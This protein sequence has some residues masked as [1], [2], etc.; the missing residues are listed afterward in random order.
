MS[1]W[2]EVYRSNVAALTAL[3]EGL[4]VE[5]LSLRVPAT[6]DW[7]VHDVLAHLAGSPADVLSGRMDGAP[8]AEWT[9]R[10]VAE[11]SARTPE[12]LVTELRGSVDGV[13]AS[14]DGSDSPA[15]VWNAAVHHADLH[16]ALGKGAP[17]EVHWR[18]VLEALAP[19]ALG[20]HADA[21]AGVPDYELFRALFSRRSRA[22]MAAWGTPLDQE[23]LDAMCLFGPRD[24]DQ[25]V[26]ER[27]RT[28]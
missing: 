2:A 3:A 13:V 27:G 24:D 7:D 19:R 5:Q 1:D 6:P 21:V 8:S 17:P 9:A 11:R 28:A 14:L 18:P 4:S 10:H 26:P 15:L 20:E 23:T 22:Q 16:E 12:D 25:P